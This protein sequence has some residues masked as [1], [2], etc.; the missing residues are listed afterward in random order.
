MVFLSSL[1]CQENIG[2]YPGNGQKRKLTELEFAFLGFG[3][4]RFPHVKKVSHGWGLSYQYLNYFIA[5]NDSEF[6][7]YL[8]KHSFGHRF[9]IGDMLKAKYIMRMEIF[10][11]IC[12]DLSPF[13]SVSHVPKQ[14][15]EA[16]F[17]FA[18]GIETEVGFLKYKKVG[19]STVLNFRKDFSTSHF[20]FS[21]QPIKLLIRFNFS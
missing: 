5:S 4:K 17:F 12:L 16:G 20:Y 21:W 6:K 8:E 1:N 9:S 18:T 7:Y 14:G 10:K 19:A 3:I 11:S 2:N 13:L 15:Q